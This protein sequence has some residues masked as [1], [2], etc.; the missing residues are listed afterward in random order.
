LAQGCLWFQRVVHRPAIFTDGYTIE[1]NIALYLFAENE[2]ILPG[3]Q[4]R[5]PLDETARLRQEQVSMVIWVSEETGDLKC[6]MPA[7]L[8]Q[9]RLPEEMIFVGSG[10]ASLGLQPWVELVA[11]KGIS[12]KVLHL[13]GANRGIG[14]NQAIRQASFPLIAA[15][16]AE[17]VPPPDWLEKLV[18]PFEIDPQLQLCAGTGELG[19]PDRLDAEQFIPAL[20]SLAFTK[21]TWSLAG[22]FPEWLP[23]GEDRYFSLELKRCT[24]RWAFVPEAQVNAATP[25]SAAM[26]WHT[27]YQLAESDGRIGLFADHYW[28]VAQAFFLKY[29]L[30]LIVFAFGL[31]WALTLQPLFALCG[32]TL[33]LVA[34]IWRFLLARQER[35]GGGPGFAN[36]GAQLQG[37]TAGAAA[38][39]ET[40][41]KRLRAARKVLFL[42]SG[43]PMDDTGGGARPAQFAL[44]ALRQGEVVVY[45]HK[46]PK[47]ER[48]ELNL[49][50]NHPNL[51]SYSAAD[52]QLANF[53]RTTA[54]DLSRKPALALVEI[55]LADWLPHIQAL[56]RAGVKVVYDLMDDWNTDLGADW[57]SPETEATIVSLADEVIATAPLLQE[58]L[59]EKFNRS[60]PLFPNAVNLRRFNPDR[61]YP[62]P[63]DLPDAEWVILYIGAL[64]GSWFDW[65]LLLEVARAYPHAA[66]VVI[67]DYRGQSPQS[68]PNLDFL[69]LKAN[70]DLPAY[71]AHGD[72]AIIPW[73]VNAITAATSPLKL[74][75]YL[76]MRKPVVAPDLPLLRATPGVVCAP[77]AE[78]F[79]RQV[80]LSRGRALDVQVLEP[81][82]LDNSWQTRLPALW[83]LVEQDPLSA[84]R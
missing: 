34:V 73:K 3:Y 77:G 61:F 24:R 29:A 21:D 41:R 20:P 5:C 51:F 64:W 59:Q 62:R 6:W 43:V 32:A 38:R 37:F 79:V 80:G 14:L 26:L 48:D 50:F 13:P 56:R 27:S 60:A 1:T 82:L 72:V 45:I 83:Q 23:G 12:L 70:Q 10:K 66:V 58:R 76:A 7:L 74:Y 75:E 44:E 4:P 67:G 25:K 17:G 49:R 36:S 46:Y 65:D 2:R 18:L 31:V 55:P 11:G 78:D 9:S 69:G 68:L 40:T 71:L 8:E 22:G 35:L 57:Y 33:A 54:L 81:Y 47:F 39:L 84:A 53:L 16:L 15:T 52:F 19:I 30:F 63:P 42:L 28:R